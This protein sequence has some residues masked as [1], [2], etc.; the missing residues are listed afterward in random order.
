MIAVDS[1]Q[2]KKARAACQAIFSSSPVKQIGFCD[3]YSGNMD[4]GK[5]YEQWEKQQTSR[6]K[7]SER[8]PGDKSGA[9]AGAF[10]ETLEQWLE[11]HEPIDKDASTER[12][13]GND[14]SAKISAYTRFKRL[15][16]QDELDPHGMRETEARLAVQSF[17]ARCAAK[18]LEK[19]S[20][21]HGKGNHSREEQ[22]LVRVVREEL[23]RNPHAGK[24]GFADNQHGGRGATW[25]RVRQAISRDK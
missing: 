15:Q 25:V 17:I 12:R 8:A 21:I 4:F 20:I 18:G 7:S 9:E 13:T 22:V 24:F 16:P 19:V 14:K 1:S 6:K 3:M 10:R 2:N 23:E 5:I 11:A